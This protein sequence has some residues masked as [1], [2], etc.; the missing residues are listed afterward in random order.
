MTTI[1]ELPLSFKDL[2]RRAGESV[3]PAD[4]DNGNKTLRYNSCNVANAASR[5]GGLTAL[6]NTSVDNWPVY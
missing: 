4:V 5:F 1:Q 6:R 3:P 2:P